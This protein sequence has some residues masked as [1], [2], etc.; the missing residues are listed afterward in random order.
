MVDEVPEFAGD[1]FDGV[2]D[3]G[4]DD[5]AGGEFEGFLFC[6]FPVDLDFGLQVHLLVEVEDGFDLFL[7][8]VLHREVIVRG[9]EIFLKRGGRPTVPH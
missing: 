5:G 7:D 8:E 1:V 2:P 6:C 3:D 4:V 9:V